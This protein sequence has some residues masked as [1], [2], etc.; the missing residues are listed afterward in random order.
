MRQDRP[1]IIFSE[2]VCLCELV[3]GE[4]N[5]RRVGLSASCL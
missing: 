2:L 1:Y 5:C 3:I 4:L